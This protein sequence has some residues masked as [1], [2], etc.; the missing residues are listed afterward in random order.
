MTGDHGAIL[1][2]T[3]P[4]ATVTYHSAVSNIYCIRYKFKIVRHI[5]LKIVLQR[6]QIDLESK[7][8]L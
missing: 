1:E 4:K 7:F 2:M 6:F 3:L 5:L 8:P